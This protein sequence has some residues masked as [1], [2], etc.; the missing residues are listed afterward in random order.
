MS[1]P[2]Q[3][4]EAKLEE[5]ILQDVSRPSQRSTKSVRISTAK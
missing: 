1:T 3:S 2:G 5:N 4:E